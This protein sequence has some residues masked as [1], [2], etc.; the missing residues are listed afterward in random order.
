MWLG[1]RVPGPE[2]TCPI[3]PLRHTQTLGN[4]SQ[5]PQVGSYR[6]NINREER[7]S[8]MSIVNPRWYIEDILMKINN[9]SYVW[10]SPCTE[11]NKTKR[12][13]SS[14]FDIWE[15]KIP[16]NDTRKF[17]F[18]S[19]VSFT[20]FNRNPEDTD[21]G[22]IFTFCK[23]YP[24][25]GRE[26]R[27]LGQKTTSINTHLLSCQTFITLLNRYVFKGRKPLWNETVWLIE[28]LK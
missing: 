10:F 2:R 14:R 23:H 26:A 7:D 17:K 4:N 6:R 5:Y 28:H 15:V 24:L 1:G 9:S 13:S 25:I 21:Y 11:L 3:R 20:T 16:I 19:V 18:S 22:I 27:Q 8:V 12:N